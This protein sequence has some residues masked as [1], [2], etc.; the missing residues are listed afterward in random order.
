MGLVV[1][2]N[3]DAGVR[4]MQKYSFSTF[5]EIMKSLSYQAINTVPALMK[6]HQILES[7]DTPSYS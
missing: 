2:V 5:F 1:Q 6:Y 7:T 3:A 4:Y